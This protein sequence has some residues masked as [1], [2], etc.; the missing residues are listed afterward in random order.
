MGKLRGRRLS[1]RHIV[2][3]IVGLGLLVELPLAYHF[4]LSDRTGGASAIPQTTTTTTT[5]VGFSSLTSHPIAGNFKPDRTKLGDCSADDQACIQQ[6]FGNLAY[7]Q[8]PKAALALVEKKYPGGADPA[9]HPV[10]HR[11]GAGALARFHGNIARTFAA[12]SSF[13]W[14]GYYHGV[15]ERAFLSLKVFNAKT[16]GAKARTICRSAEIEADS[17]LSYQCLHGLGHGLMIT[18]AY[19]LPFALSVCRQLQT[20]WDQTSCKGG[21]FMENFIT[22]YGGDSP[23]VRPNDAMFPCDRVRQ[24]DKY[25]CYQQVTTRMIRMFGLDWPRMARLCAHAER[26]WSATC[27]GSFGQNASVQNFR[28]P[29]KTAQTCAI[30]RRYGGEA[31]CLEYAAEDIAG[32]YSSGTQAATL[33]NLTAGNVRPS[34]FQA[35]GRLLRYLRSTPERRVAECHAIAQAAA[36]VAACIHGTRKQS[37]IPGLNRSPSRR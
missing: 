35:I 14:S 6:A 8:G 31:M 36:D 22:S 2:V 12:G 5:Q 1:S 21:V 18:T 32:T 10:M 29:K 20:D 3:L 37:S 23:W 17:W 30:T 34:C 13:C 33:C 4:F 28:N 7:Y 26:G 9:C 25:T 15:L 27:F 24:Q 16:L 11:I 19:Q